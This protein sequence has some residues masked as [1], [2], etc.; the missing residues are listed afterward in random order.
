MAHKRR[1]DPYE[2][3]QV[4]VSIR[5]DRPGISKMYILVP[6]LGICNET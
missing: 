3:G 2:D 1:R 6:T 4:D 5:W